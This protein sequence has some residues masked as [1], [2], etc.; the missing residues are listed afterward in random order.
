MVSAE[1]TELKILAE[2][3]DLNEKEKVKLQKNLDRQRRANTPNKFKEDGT[4]NISN[5]E[6]W[7]KIGNAKIQRDLYSAYLIKKVTENL[8]E[9]EIE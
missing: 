3:I 7:L 6:R 8:K 5:K 4:I 2:N 1:Q 9:V